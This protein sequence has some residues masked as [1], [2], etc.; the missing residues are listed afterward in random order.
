MGSDSL[1]ADCGTCGK[2]ISI[3]ARSCP[4]CGARRSRFGIGKWIGGGVIAIFVLAVI[5]GPDTSERRQ[6]DTSKTE[7]SIAAA[8]T[9]SSLPEQQSR[10]LSITAGY[11]DRFRSAAN[12]LQQSA[13][14]D[15]RRVALVKALGSQHG[16]NGWI[17]TI[18]R[19]ETTSDG[20]AILAVRL[21]PNTEI[22]TWNNGLSDIVDATLIDKGTPLYNALLTMSV[23]DTVAVSGSLY[24]SDA[25]GVKETSLT[26][27]GSMSEPEF[28]FHFQDVSKQ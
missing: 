24:P 23:G 19:L 6:T 2:Q 11:S 25:D 14:R 18:S 12:E 21:S 16:V 9:A 28:L 20:K 22:A 5:A 10:F 1:W 15:E 7:P 17:G 27:R 13:L 3:S 8:A 26:I 4:H